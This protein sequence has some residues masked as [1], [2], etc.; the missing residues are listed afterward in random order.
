MPQK[1]A[2]DGILSPHLGHNR[3]VGLVVVSSARAAI[4]RPPH[5]PQNVIWPGLSKLQLAHFIRRIPP[6][7][8]LQPP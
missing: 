8:R 2:W 1:A 6:E 7:R 5:L 3:V 4:K